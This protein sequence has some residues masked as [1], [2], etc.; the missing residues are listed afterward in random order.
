V[1]IA[2]ILSGLGAGGAE[3]VVNLIARHRQTVG[4]R[5]DIVAVNADGPESYFP[6]EAGTGIWPLGS[7]Q[8]GAAPLGITGRQ[9][10]ALHGRL[11][12]L[13]PDLVISF[14]T[15]I[16]I[17]S[18]LAMLGLGAPLVMSERNNFTTQTMSPVWRMAQPIAA[19]R[20]FR[21]VMQT[22]AAR[23]ALSPALRARAIV[24]PNPAGLPDG[25]PTRPANDARFVAVGRLEPQKGF[26]LL[27][28]AFARV[29]RQ[30]P[31]AQL[32]IFGEGPQRALLEQQASTLGIGDHVTLAGLTP[33]PGDWI[34]SADIFVLS[35]RYEGFPNVLIE[36]MVAGLATIAFDCPWGPAEIIASPDTGIQVPPGDAGKLGDAMLRLAIDPALRHQISAAG[37]EAAA[38]HYS[39]PAVLAQWDAVIEG[40]VSA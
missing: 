10:V 16:N 9:V 4:D 1:R 38:A 26:D 21:L 25:L 2:F 19:R 8:P 5:V 13:A 39:M 34:H 7:R 23:L 17:L 20:A 37:A 33:T 35:S 32:T 15:K 24:I 28:D 30:I 40:A 18:A 36:A 27:L 12:A 22:E 6:Y 29:V 11:A 3:R 31:T 14:L